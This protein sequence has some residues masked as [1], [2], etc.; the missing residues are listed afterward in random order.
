RRRGDKHHE[1]RRDQN[2]DTRRRHDQGRNRWRRASEPPE[3]RQTARHDGP[4]RGR[5]YRNDPQAAGTYAFAPW[6][7]SYTLKPEKK[8][9]GHFLRYNPQ[10]HRS[11]T[12]D[13]PNRQKARSAKRRDL[14][15]PQARHAA[16]A[17]P[18]RYRDDPNRRR[19]RNG[20]CLKR[21]SGERA[22][23]GRRAVSRLDHPV[24]ESA[25]PAV[26]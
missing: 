18:S 7:E 23:A 8:F 12:H 5:Q 11:K 14:F 16:H 3:R 2:Y 4:A 25:L 22:A 10:T 15:V 1:Q 19:A 9:P 13:Y 24:S 17:P 26:A 6:R 21:Y 20:A